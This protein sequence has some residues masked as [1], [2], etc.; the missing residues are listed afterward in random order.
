M[1]VWEQ[2]ELRSKKSLGNSKPKASK[3][4][5][6]KGPEKTPKVTVE[7]SESAAVSSGKNKEKDSQNTDKQSQPTSSTSTATSVPD[8]A[9]KV[10]ANQIELSVTKNQYP[11]NLEN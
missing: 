1:Q 3:V 7:N 5:I 6:M 9:T 10:V 8:S 4:T 2:Y 11:F